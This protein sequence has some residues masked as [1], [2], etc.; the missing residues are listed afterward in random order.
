MERIQKVIAAS[1]ICSRR[2]AEELLVQGRV[3]V[4]GKIITELGTQVKKSDQITVDEEQLYKENKVYFLMNKP[5]K[6]ICSNQDEFARKSV[7]D[8]IDCPQRIFS[9]GRLDYDTSGLL[10]L[11]NDGDFS[12]LLTHPSFR[13]PKVYNLTINALLTLTDQEAIKKGILLDDGIQTQPA[14]IK[15]IKKEPKKKLTT[16]DL[17]IFEGKNRQIKRMMETLGYK[18][19]RLHRKEFAF[20][21][22]SDLRQGEYRLLKPF[23]IKRLKSLAQAGKDFVK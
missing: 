4:N 15:N 3:K 1:G 21:H 8:I 20:L 7:I 6:T 9:I 10:L 13:I 12:N 23:E 11:S 22:C 18:V 5:K 19:Q 16:F 14:K 2:K 17:T